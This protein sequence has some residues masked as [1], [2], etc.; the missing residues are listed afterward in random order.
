M[1]LLFDLKRGDK[2]DV[3]V[4][5]DSEMQ[6]EAEAYWRKKELKVILIHEQKDIE[7]FMETKIKSGK[8]AAKS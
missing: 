8:M 3:F 7:R 6:R 2:D 4:K 5:R 1:V